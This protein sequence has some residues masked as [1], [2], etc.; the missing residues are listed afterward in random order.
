MK[1]IFQKNWWIIAVAILVIAVIVIVLLATKQNQPAIEQTMEGTAETTAPAQ[2]D[3]TL[4]ETK[5]T[6]APEGVYVEILN[7]E[8]V[9]NAK[10]AEKVFFREN[11]DTVEKD[12][13]VYTKINDQEYMVFTIVSD[14]VEGDIVQMVSDT[15]G[16]KI[17]VAF[18]MNELPEGVADEAANEFYIVQGVVN[19]IIESIRMK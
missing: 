15:A 14:S 7:F 16:T 2:M 5:Q 17:P 11:E 3:E 10:M 13:T 4:D 8:F 1:N 18:V 19:E 12:V 6:S 9:L